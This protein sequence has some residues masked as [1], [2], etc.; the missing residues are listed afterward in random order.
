MAM[1]DYSK[2]IHLKANDVA[3]KIL[4]KLNENKALLIHDNLEPTPEEQRAL[5]EKTMDF[6]IDMM[7]MLAMEGVTANYATFSLDKIIDNL[8]GLKQYIKGSLAAYEDE[9]L[10]RSYGIKN[11]DG[12]FR[13][14]EITVG[15]LMLKLA[16][17]Q[18]A[19]GGNKYDFINEVAPEMPKD[20]AGEAVASPFVA[21]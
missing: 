21:E 9:Y 18:K 3:R 19:T 1:T 2:K 5:D 10:S 8:G 4:E 17:I 14:E 20:D 6:G 13:K 16:E 12:K 7:K 11:E 15:D